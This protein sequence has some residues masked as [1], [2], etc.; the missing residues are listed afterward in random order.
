MPT[1]RQLTVTAPGDREI[2]MS[3]VF[4]APRHLVFEAMMR[5]DLLKRWLNGPPGWSLDICEVDGRVGGALRHVW[6]H[7]DGREMGMG[8]VFREIAPPE[9]IVRTELFDED[10]TGGEALATLVLIEQGGST[11]LDV[12]MLYASSEARDGVL[13]S[14]MKD[15]VSVSYDSLDEVLE[16][17]RTAPRRA[18][19]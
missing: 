11:R 10:W 9:R 12:T 8:G 7:A 14:G 5:P 17:D 6:R 13:A 3:R 19:A 4:D 16:A 2:L 15:G 1:I 18:S